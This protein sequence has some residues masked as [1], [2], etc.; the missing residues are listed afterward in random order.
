MA[1]C[2]SVPTGRRGRRP[3]RTLSTDSRSLRPKRSN[4]LPQQWVGASPPIFRKACIRAATSGRPYGGVRKFVQEIATS[5]FALLAMT[6]KPHCHCE[7]PKEAWQSH[8]QDHHVASLLAMTEE[9]LLTEHQRHRPL[10]KSVKLHCYMVLQG[11]ASLTAS[12]SK[13][14]FPDTRCLF[15][16]FFILIGICRRM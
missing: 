3:L 15:V 4:T 12:R 5:G 9:P 6:T 13:V 14:V 7:P 11:S 2:E 1:I 10:R 16:N 8:A